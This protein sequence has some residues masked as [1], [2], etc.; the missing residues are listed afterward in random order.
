MKDVAKDISQIVDNIDTNIYG[1]FLPAQHHIETCDVKYAR[2]FKYLHFVNTQGVVDRTTIDHLENDDKIYFVGNIPMPDPQ[3]F[4]QKPFFISGTHT[5]ANR[6]WSILNKDL[7]KKTPIIWLLE[8]IRM[9]KF[10]RGST[11]DYTSDLRI[12]FLDE[13]NPA[14]YKTKDHREQAVEPMTRL[15]ELFIKTIEKDRQYVAIDNYEMIT[16]S[17]FGVERQDGIFQNILD[18]NLS[19]VELRISL[20]KYKDNCKC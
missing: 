17:R 18:A 20:T 2:R 10:G 15:A 5:S 1:K 6:E 9:E 19:G 13:T 12:F 4:L 14:Q 8:T 11:Y 16:F 7:Y 3:F